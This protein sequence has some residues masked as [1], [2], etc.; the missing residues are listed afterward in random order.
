MTPV[1]PGPR[2]ENA[3]QYCH[4]NIYNHA[5]KGRPK[6]SRS[7]VGIQFRVCM[8][9][10]EVSAPFPSDPSVAYSICK[11]CRDIVNAIVS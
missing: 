5:L 8:V 10:I 3:I 7:N 9:R 6:L 4:T 11:L 1:M 2:E